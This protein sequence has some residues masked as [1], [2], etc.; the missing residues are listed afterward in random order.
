VKQ[1][2]TPRTDSQHAKEA[3]SGQTKERLVGSFKAGI[4]ASYG[5]VQPTPAGRG[6]IAQ[7]LTPMERWQKESL[8]EGYWNHLA[9]LSRKG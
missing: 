4:A 9:A 6:F 2:S 5:N 7:G 8:S 1:T 3:Q